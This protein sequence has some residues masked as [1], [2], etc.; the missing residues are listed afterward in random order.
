MDHELYPYQERRW[1]KLLVRTRDEDGQGSQ[2]QC[3]P[4]NGQLDRQ[5][6]A[7]AYLLVS[8]FRGEWEGHNSLCFYRFDPKKRRYCC[9]L[10]SHTHIHTRVH[11]YPHTYKY[12]YLHVHIHT[13]TYTCMYAHTCMYMHIH[14]CIH[15]YTHKYTCICRQMRYPQSSFAHR[16]QP[17]PS[18]P[19]L[20]FKLT[21]SSPTW[22]PHI[23]L[24]PTMSSAP[25]C[26]HFPLCPTSLQCDPHEGK[27]RVI[28]VTNFAL[29]IGPSS[30]R[31]AL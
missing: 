20:L 2:H 15:M 24:L 18:L 10:I 11:A 21:S 4:A 28:V 1:Q 8:F 7:A 14:G 13:C 16:P 12:M 19:G 31:P 22:S 30:Q 5:G 23:L 26:G 29:C 6:W 9:S 27:L 25:L 3:E 17:Q